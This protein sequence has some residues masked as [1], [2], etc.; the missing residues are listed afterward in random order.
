MALGV[1]VKTEAKT[2]QEKEGGRVFLPS[3]GCKMTYQWVRT[4]SVHFGRKKSRKVKKKK[5]KMVKRTFW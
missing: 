1:R 4:I 2:G 3:R 5:S